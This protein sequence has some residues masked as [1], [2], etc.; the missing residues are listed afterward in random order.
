MFLVK[1]KCQARDW[2]NFQDGSEID[3]NIGVVEDITD[4]KMLLAILLHDINNDESIIH[5]EGGETYVAELDETRETPMIV[6]FSADIDL[7]WF[8]IEL[9][10]IVWLDHTTIKNRLTAE[11]G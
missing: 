6:V 5:G 3:A 10:P 11:I 8:T 2:P 1:R 7:V 4:A 9:E